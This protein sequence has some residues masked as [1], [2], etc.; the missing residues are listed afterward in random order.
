MFRRG[1]E[2]RPT[3]AN[4]VFRAI[5]PVSPAAMAIRTGCIIYRRGSSQLGGANSINIEAW[6]ISTFDAT[7]GGSCFHRVRCLCAAAQSNGA[8]MS[9]TRSNIGINALDFVTAAGSVYKD[10]NGNS[11]IGVVAEYSWY[12]PGN[13]PMN[14]RGL[15]AVTVPDQ[16]GLAGRWQGFSGG[17]VGSGMASIA[18]FTDTGV[19]TRTLAGT[20]NGETIVA[21]GDDIPWP[22]T[23]PGAAALLP[24][25]L[26]NPVSVTAETNNLCV[27]GSSTPLVAANTN[28]V[29]SQNLT[30]TSCSPATCVSGTNLLFVRSNDEDTGVRPIN[31][32][33]IPF[34][35]SPDIIIVPHNETVTVDSASSEIVLTPG[36]PYDAFVR[37]HNDYSCSD[38][39][40]GVQA[41][42]FLADPEALSTPWMD[43]EITNGN[44]LPAGGITVKA[45]QP[46]HQVPFPFSAPLS[47][48]GNG[49]RCALADI[50]TSDEPA[51]SDLFD[52]LSSY[53]VAQRNLQLSDCAYSLTNSS[54][55]NGNVSLT[56]SLTAGPPPAPPLVPS[57]ASGGI[58]AWVAFSDPNGV[59]AG[60]WANQSG[61]GTAFSVTT[62]GSGANETT[63]VQLGQATIALTSVSLPAGQSRTASANITGLAAGAQG[64]LSLQAVLTDASTGKQLLAN[65]GSCAMTGAP[66][67]K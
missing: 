39:M 26:V 25:T 21:S 11:L 32:N 67:P 60:V 65:G 31:L 36:Q 9:P 52:P 43:G 30:S 8:N 35:E 10:N 44:Y 6:D 13:D 29:T 59:W 46:G 55:D 5:R 15:Y 3:W 20:C 53:Q 23:C 2:R 47:G 57:L 48:V 16:Y 1:L 38:A 49:H 24:D 7:G 22:G 12:D 27:V 66:S 61:A 18:Q 17:V 41:R 54:T 4:S 50:I 19:L 56:L 33:G 58:N 63:T 34:W 37:V 45:G 64:D 28:L 62:T 51:P 14:N 40:I 42:V